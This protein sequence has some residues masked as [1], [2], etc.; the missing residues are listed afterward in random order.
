MVE[1]YATMAL[2]RK[3]HRWSF[4]EL[5]IHLTMS[6][7]G[8]LKTLQSLKEMKVAGDQEKDL[9]W[10]K[11]VAKTTMNALMQVAD[12]I[13]YRF[14]DYNLAMCQILWGNKTSP[15]A[16]LQK[17]FGNA[18]EL[19]CVMNDVG[20]WGTQVLLC[21]IN[22]ITNVGDFLLK[23]KDV[24]EI[25][26]V[27]AGKKSRGSRITRQKDRMEEIVDF[28]NVEGGLI[29]GKK[30]E[31]VRLSCRQHKLHDL[32]EAF[33]ESEV[34]GTAF[35][36]LNDYQ[37]ISC[38]DV[39]ALKSGN[40]RERRFSEAIDELAERSKSLW[41][42]DRCIEISSLEHRQRAGITAPLT[43]YPIDTSIIV[44]VLMGSK[45]YISTINL[46]A[47]I[48]HIESR[49]WDVLDLI[50][51]EM[52]PEQREAS[53]FSVFMLFRKENSNRNVT[54]PVDILI[55]CATELIDVDC[56]LDF[57]ERIVQQTPEKRHWI[58]F[59]ENE[60]GIWR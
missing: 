34:R 30:A 58:P 60:E 24:F 8:E 6:M 27:K 1:D 26:E 29:K 55:S 22:S 46:D 33:R 25:I 28:L 37:T 45:I 42:N 57:C 5:Q 32:E 41:G 43:V 36:Q 20:D 54:F 56:Y 52:S 12:G 2:R 38:I 19:A 14:L 9:H 40:H 11:Q 10:M 31:L 35:K 7:I 4:V 51:D 16:I 44:D 13:A 39:G 17:G 50:E 49:G 18:I 59:Y 53:D 48:A 23:T 21:D 47:L 15:Y 3:D